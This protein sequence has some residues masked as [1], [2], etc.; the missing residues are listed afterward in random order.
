MCPIPDDILPIIA[1]ISAAGGHPVIV[2][3]WVREWV[4][5]GNGRSGDGVIRTDGV[6]GDMDIEVFGISSWEKLVEI[7]KPF[8][9]ISPVGRIYAVCKVRTSCREIDLALPRCD[10]KTGPGHRGFSVEIFPEISFEAAASR[11]DF[12]INA[13]GWDVQSAMLLDPF[14]G[15]ADIKNGVIRHVGSQFDSDPLRVFRAARFAGRFGYKIHPT[16]IAQCDAMPI[17]ELSTDRIRDEIIRLLMDSPR[18]SDG[19]RWFPDL[20]I[21][22]YLS[23]LLPMLTCPNG[24]RN[25]ESVWD[26]TIM[27]V[28]RVAGQSR[29]LRLLLAA[30]CHDLGKPTT[31]SRSKNGQPFFPGH[32]M[33][34]RS[35][36]D[37]LLDKIGM[38]RSIQR[39]VG[40]LVAIHGV[41]S[42][43]AGLPPTIQNCRIRRLADQ[44]FL[45]DLGVLEQ[46][47]H[48]NTDDSIT[49]IDFSAR[50]IQ[51]GVW[52]GPLPILV[53]GDILKKKGVSAN[54][55]IGRWMRAIRALQ[56][57]GVLPSES[58]CRAWLD[59]ILPNE[60]I[61]QE[62]I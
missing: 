50:A 56:C 8:G 60:N 11:R 58:A 14:E 34:G 40:D 7:L 4:R 9:V 18:P 3:G 42:D 38:S 1:A 21:L 16:T 19:L 23:E 36:A 12:T 48:P 31:L 2:G 55:K 25:A 37:S 51:L 32:E 5:S 26:H 33:M 28:D 43:L 27:V 61:L 45:P 59:R 54:L 44:Y 20:G 29:L 47:N 49:G 52:D 17:D 62:V 15:Q 46:A 10:V 41:I 6:A 53:S 57:A 39:R 35:L 24:N 13:M 22:N 30:L